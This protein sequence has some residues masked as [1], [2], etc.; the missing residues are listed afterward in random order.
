MK[1]TNKDEYDGLWKDY[2]RH[3]EGI[4]KDAVSGNVERRL[5]RYDEVKEVLEVMQK[6]M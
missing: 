3:G 6:D 2:R 4:F 5:Y 1:Y